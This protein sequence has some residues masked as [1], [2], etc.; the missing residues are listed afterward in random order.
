MDLVFFTKTRKDMTVDELARFGEQTGLDG[1]DL[2]VRP[3]HPVH[4]DNVGD[5]LPRAAEQLGQHGLCIAMVTGNF[6]LL[7]PDQPAARPLLRAMNAAGVRLLKLGYFKFDPTTQD[8]WDEVA[9]TRSALAGWEAMGRE[10]G[11][12]VCY[13][14]HSNRCLGLNA[15]T[16]AHLL[17]GRDPA[18]IGAY[19]DPCHLLIEGEAFDVA[20]AILRE[21]LSIVA[22]KDVLLSR[23]PQEPHGRLAR[24]IVP[25]GHGMVDWTNVFAELRRIGFDGPLSIHCDFEIAASQREPQIRREIDFFRSRLSAAPLASPA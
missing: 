25:A 6:D 12:K 21:W 23:E 7:L 18:C 5:A 14:T 10:H 11:V 24:T 19:L 22:L 1:F 13:H 15:G 16:L 17:Q 8:Y 2:A 9:K 4:P 3:G 20:A